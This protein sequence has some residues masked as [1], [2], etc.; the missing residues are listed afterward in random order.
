LGAKPRPVVANEAKNTDIGEHRRKI[1]AEGKSLQSQGDIR[2]YRL[3]AYPLKTPIFCFA[4]KGSAVRIR[5]SPPRI[6][7]ILQGIA[8]SAFLVFS[9]P[10]TF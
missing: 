1:K 3:S 6:S 10:A 2:H 4:C 7:L 8:G 9:L 5:S